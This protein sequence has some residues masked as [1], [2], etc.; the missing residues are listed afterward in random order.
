MPKFLWKSH[1]ND[2][3]GE[4]KVLLCLMGGEQPSSYLKSRKTHT[5]GVVLCLG[6]LTPPPSSS[7][8]GLGLLPLIPF[9]W[10]QLCAQWCWES[11]AA[12]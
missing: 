3:T 1:S 9:P 5:R 10:Q 8:L 6:I 4:S 11:L 7:A 2:S 12:K